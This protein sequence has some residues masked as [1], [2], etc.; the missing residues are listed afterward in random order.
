MINMRS[1]SWF[2][3]LV[4]V[5]YL[6]GLGFLMYLVAPIPE[7]LAEE[8]DGIWWTLDWVAKHFFLGR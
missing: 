1:D 8:F 5:A 7:R 4:I 3:L 2:M 6:I